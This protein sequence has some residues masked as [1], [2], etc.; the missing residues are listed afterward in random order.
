MKTTRFP[1][2]PVR[3]AAI[4]H[5]VKKPGKAF[6]GGEVRGPMGWDTNLEASLFSLALVTA[7]GRIT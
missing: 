5:R 1:P 7:A 4:V 6:I 2:Q 3:P